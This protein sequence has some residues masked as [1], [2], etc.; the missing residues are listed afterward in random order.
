MSRRERAKVEE[1]LSPNV[2]PM[3]DIMFLLLLFFMLS[4][5]MTQRRTEEVAL[6]RASHALP[7]DPEARADEILNVHHRTAPGTTCAVHENGGVCRAEDHWG[8]AVLGREYTSDALGSELQ[9]LARNHPETDV[10]PVAQKRLSAAKVLVRADGS[11]PYEDVQKVIEVC[12]RA[13]IHEVEVAAAMP[14]R[15]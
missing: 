15:R 13:T 5:D 9:D 1:S 3:I 4:A 14:A 10:D 8:W 6:P 2:I 7:E 11:A 12:G